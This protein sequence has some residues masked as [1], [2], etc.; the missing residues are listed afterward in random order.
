MG[1]QVPQKLPNNRVPMYNGLKILI[2]L[3]VSPPIYPFKI[4]LLTL[5]VGLGIESR[6]LE[7]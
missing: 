6:D 2:S 1:H 4:S 5:V 3:L 7:V